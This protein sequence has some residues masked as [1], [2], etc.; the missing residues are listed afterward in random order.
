M[1]SGNPQFSGLFDCLTKT[2]AQGGFFSMYN[3]FGAP[4]VRVRARVRVGVEV[5]TQ[6]KPSPWSAS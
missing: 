2:M 5:R 1:G 3:G 6:L 4:L